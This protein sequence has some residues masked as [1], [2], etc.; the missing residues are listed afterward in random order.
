MFAKNYPHFFKKNHNY[1]IFKLE[2][3]GWGKIVIIFGLS[4]CKDSSTKDSSVDEMDG[5]LLK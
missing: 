3:R 4:G 1:L 5:E 2:L